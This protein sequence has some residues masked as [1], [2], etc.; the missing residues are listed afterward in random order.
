MPISG[1]DIGV[2]FQQEKS[3]V[4]HESKGIIFP[5]QQ[6][7]LLTLAIRGGAFSAPSGF[8]CVIGKRGKT[9]SPYLVTF[10]KYSLR[11]F[12]QKKLPGQVRSGQV[13]RDDC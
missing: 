2:S 5:L 11:T 3:Y 1:S 9:E 4:K 13:T 8:S 7:I 12:W 10:S 6:H